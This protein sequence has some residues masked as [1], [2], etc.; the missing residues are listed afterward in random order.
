MTLIVNVLLV[1]LPFF[2]H[3]LILTTE[4]DRPYG[5]Q[6]YFNEKGTY[7]D[8]SAYHT[9]LKTL[10]SNFTF[11]TA[12]DYGFYNSSYGQ[13]L[14]TVYM[15]RLCKGDLTP[16]A[17]IKMMITIRKLGKPLFK[18]LMKSKHMG[19]K[20]NLF[21]KTTKRSLAYRILSFTLK[22]H[23]SNF[24]HS[25]MT[26]TATIFLALISLLS[27]LLVLTAR[28]D[29]SFYKCFNERGNYTKPSAYHTNLNTL[30]SN[31]TFDTKIDYG[32]Y[33]SSYGEKPNTV[34]ALGMCRGDVKPDSCRNCLNN[35]TILLP[36]QCPYQKEAFGYYNL[37]MFRYSSRQMSG[38]YQDTDFH[39]YTSTDT[40]AADANKY[41]NLLNHLMQALTNKARDGNSHRKVAAGNATVDQSQVVYGLVQCTPDLNGQDCFDCLQD[42]LFYIP[43]CCQNKAGG[44]I[45]KLS[46][47]IRFENF[48][49]YDLAHA[50]SIKITLP[51]ALSPSTN[52]T[53]PQGSSNKSTT[54]IVV[55][56][57]AIIALLIAFFMVTRKKKT[58]EIET[59]MKDDDETK[60][61]EILQIDYNTIKLATDNFSDANKL[62]QGG[63]GPVYKV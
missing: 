40:N 2:C 25:L 51:F 33:N 61:A 32:F 12:D 60:L 16:D 46:C 52:T 44:T 22:S 34:N 28:P 27:H 37:C 17:Y 10:L 56:I 42:S 58:H 35:A 54:T 21:P 23:L 8:K 55:L 41:N 48:L 45:I 38:I 62:G 14:D 29:S 15:S 53:S 36:K 57:G 43:Y 39:N 13:H 47:N 1:L 6:T 26:T 24:I 11:S 31:F 19:L 59:T 30:L 18:N 9:N 63:F 49:F 7:K 50:D 20:I 4:Q 5:N 3:L